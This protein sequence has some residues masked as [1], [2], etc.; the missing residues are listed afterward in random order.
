MFHSV[1]SKEKFKFK[2]TFTYYIPAPPVRK[3]GYHEKEFDIVCAHVIQLGFHLMDIKMQS[4]SFGEGGGVW[5]V[6]ILG[7][8]C[9]KLRDM[10]I[11]IDYANI[12][13]QT[14]P[15]NPDIIHEV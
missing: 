7:T 8:N 4:H 13:N 1:F 5:M 15:L 12:A 9:E 6:C 14:Q 2:K 3:N 10:K 11:E